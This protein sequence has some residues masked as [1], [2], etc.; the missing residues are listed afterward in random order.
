MEFTAAGL[1]ELAGFT[2]ADLR[3]LQVEA[4]DVIEPDR[5][6]PHFRA[7]FIKDA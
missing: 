5:T 4:F 2:A 1:R 3:K 6:I 7:H